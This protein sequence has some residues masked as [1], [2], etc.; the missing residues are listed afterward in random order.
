MAG[1]SLTP[2]NVELQPTARTVA[3]A[4]AAQLYITD[5]FTLVDDQPI[6]F[7]QLLDLPA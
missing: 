4:S 1:V 5:R 6:V 3:G 7:G 2:Q